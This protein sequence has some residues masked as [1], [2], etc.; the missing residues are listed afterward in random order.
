VTRVGRV[1]ICGLV[2]VVFVTGHAERAGAQIQTIANL[3]IGDGVMVVKAAP[4]KRVYVGA[5]S[6]TRTVTLTFDAGAVD[7]FV[8]EAQALVTLGAHRLPPRTIDRPMLEEQPSARALSVTRQVLHGG[9]RPPAHLSYHFFVSDDRLGGFTLAA[10]PAE[11]TAILLSL[12]R[13]SRAA[14]ALSGSP[15]PGRRAPK[16]QVSP[17]PA[18][19]PAST[20][21]PLPA[22]PTSSPLPPARGPS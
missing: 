3:V 8:A 20:P 16:K 4:G 17:S 1:G 19:H 12:H 14:Y 22:P 5:A 13:A 10:T 6:S 11:T 7:E 15:V 18:P 2:A 21:P 9:A